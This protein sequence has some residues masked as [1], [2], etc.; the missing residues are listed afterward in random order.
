MKKKISLGAKCTVK[1]IKKENKE[2][3]DAN[4]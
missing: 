4:K 3:K 2:N 1:L